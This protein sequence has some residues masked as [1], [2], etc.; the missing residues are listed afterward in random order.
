MVEE[1]DNNRAKAE[2]GDLRNPPRLEC[3][4]GSWLRLTRR[5]AARLDNETGLKG[6][7][8]VLWGNSEASGAGSV[9]GRDESRARLT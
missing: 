8:G 1:V 5:A 9:K 7:E 3:V 4:D 2:L 6:R